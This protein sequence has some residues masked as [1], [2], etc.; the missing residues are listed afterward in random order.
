MK[1]SWRAWRRR[2]PA[3]CRRNY[4]YSSDHSFHIQACSREASHSSKRTSKFSQVKGST[5]G[6][7]PLR[8]LDAT[9]C[10]GSSLNGTP[11]L[12]RNA[13]HAESGQGPDTCTCTV[14]WEHSWRLNSSISH[15]F[16]EI[17]PS[18]SLGT[19]NLYATSYETG[20]SHHCCFRPLTYSFRVWFYS[21]IACSSLL[22]ISACCSSSP[23][24][25]LSVPTSVI[26]WVWFLCVGA[27]Q[28]GLTG[29]SLAVTPL[30]HVHVFQFTPYNH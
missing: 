1:H 11:T 22:R 23:S 5:G 21:V 2:W 27:V 8:A 19:G 16:T 24:V 30:I 20:P 4:M 17:T 3:S 28:I 25:W 9:S 29:C 14:D 26:D 10:P 18:Y 15:S 6:A 13:S 7:L 12:P